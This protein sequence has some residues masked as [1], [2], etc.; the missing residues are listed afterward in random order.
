MT[1]RQRLALAQS[2]ADAPLPVPQDLM[3]EGKW[4]VHVTDEL[5]V[6]YHC[7]RA[8]APWEDD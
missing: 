7:I 1:R 4:R 3:I 5:L 8:Y 2:K 6:L